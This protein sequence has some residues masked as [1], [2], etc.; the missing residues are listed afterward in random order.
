MSFQK[1]IKIKIIKKYAKQLAC[2]RNYAYLCKR[3]QKWFKNLIIRNL[4]HYVKN[5][6]FQVRMR[7]KRVVQFYLGNMV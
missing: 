7:L 1:K 2:F 4:P 5:E 6:F 3:N